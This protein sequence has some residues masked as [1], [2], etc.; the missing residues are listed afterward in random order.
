MES[1]HKSRI[2]WPL[3]FG[4][5]LSVGICAQVA[6]ANLT[7]TGT[8]ISGDA[9]VIVDGSSTISIGTSTATAITI[10][11]LGQTT[12]FPGTVAITGSLS[13][14]LQSANNLS[15]LN[16]TSSARTN[17]GFTAGN[18]IALS[19]SGT[20]GLATSAISQFFNDAGY[21]TSTGSSQWTTNGTNI[22][23]N[24]GNVGIGTTSPASILDVNGRTDIAG[25]PTSKILRLKS[26]DPANILN[27][28]FVTYFDKDG[29]LLTQSYEV[30]SGNYTDNGSGDITVNGPTSDSSMLAVWSDVLA[31]AVQI[32]NSDGNN[33]TARP[34]DILS[35]DQGYVLSVH[36]TGKITWGSNTSTY[37][38]QDT[39]LFRYKAAGLQTTSDFLAGGTNG[40]ILGTGTDA[41]I[42]RTA[43]SKVGIT[44]G[45][46]TTYWTIG[47]DGISYGAGTENV[48]L[49]GSVWSV[50][51]GNG[52]NY[53]GT[54]SA[55]DQR[56]QT[57]NLT[58]MSITAAGNV[59]IG[60]TQP[61]ST[62]QVVGASSTVTIGTASL[63]GC[64]EMGSTS[65]TAK[66]VY[67]T[68]DSNA[69]MTATTT[70]PSACQ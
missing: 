27:G 31:P 2:G 25:S 63:P 33:D 17:L 44:N 60:T 70:K 21:V 19:A 59:G 8:S 38:G 23:Y 35:A 14:Y 3:T 68:F 46:S 9:P 15:D 45:N 42:K 6:S 49:G 16:S 28:H 26:N 66:I 12:T 24:T 1:P 51:A 39:D 36:N 61:S 67:L 64:L 54:T 13:G 62:L 47:S 69:V 18:K 10:G 48:T 53:Y 57:S 29:G 52:V 20:I 65:G 43:A 58:R 11:R 4:I 56:F 37:A 41:G 40:V 50:D 30:I 32:R 55:W 5:L 22:Y 34:L 7:L